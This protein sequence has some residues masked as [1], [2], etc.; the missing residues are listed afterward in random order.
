MKSNLQIKLFD[1][2]NPS[3]LFKIKRSGFR[4][5]LV[6]GALIRAVIR[7]CINLTFRVFELSGAEFLHAWPRIFFGGGGAARRGAGLA[8]TE[9]RPRPSRRSPKFQRRSVIWKSE[10]M[11]PPFDILEL[12]QNSL[13]SFSRLKLALEF[14]KI[15]DKLESAYFALEFWAGTN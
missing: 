2:F 6:V 11:A 9:W 1:L 5:G 8:P 12:G 10:I 14:V 4:N 13:S 15:F 7:F 3:A